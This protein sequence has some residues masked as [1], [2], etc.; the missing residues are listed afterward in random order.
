MTE[1]SNFSF[2]EY[3]CSSSSKREKNPLFSFF[4]LNP[5][6]VMSEGNINNERTLT[7][8]ISK[9]GKR[10]RKR[11]KKE[12]PEHDNTARDNIRRKVQINYI[13]FLIKFINKINT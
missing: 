10:G 13:N 12:R 9:K 4:N 7:D 1:S 6:D 11:N 3:S 8:E 5:F 2:E